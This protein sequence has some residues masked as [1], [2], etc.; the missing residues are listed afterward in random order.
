MI[1]EKNYQEEYD[2]KKDVT[3]LQVTSFCVII[4]LVYKGK[5]MRVCTL[6]SSS[7]GNCTIVYTEKTKVLIDIGITLEDL[8]EKLNKI[9]VNPNEITAIINTHDHSDHI[10]G[11]GAFMRKYKDTLL[12]CYCDSYDSVCGKIGRV[13][14]T[15]VISFIDDPFELGEFVIN[16]FRLPH[17]ATSC[18]GY[19]ISCGN[20]KMSIATDLGHVTPEI[21]SNLVDSRL[22]ILEANHDENMLRNNP[23]YSFVLKS[24]ILGKNGHLSNITSAKVVARLAEYGVRQVVLAHL[25]EE[26][27]TPDLC[28]QTVVD[29]LSSVGVIEGEH[30]KI[31][32]AP[33]RN[34]GGIFLLK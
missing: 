6:S 22:V 34:I 28:F 23:K 11:V 14:K 15:H 4:N 25:S 19:S 3:S 7:K 2:R 26:N 29:Y 30:I 20:K 10:K 17:D 13:D 8:E 5:K 27:N 18:V 32:V 12:F 1:S 33:A 21:V 24:R 16:P 31:T 9:G